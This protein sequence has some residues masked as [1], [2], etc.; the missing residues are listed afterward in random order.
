MKPQLLAT[1]QRSAF[2]AHCD[3]IIAGET[4]PEDMGKVFEVLKALE[5]APVAGGMKEVLF[6][7]QAYVRV[8]ER[9]KVDDHKAR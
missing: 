2:H 1:D 4:R 7:G 9:A 5:K 8:P 6:R 3:R